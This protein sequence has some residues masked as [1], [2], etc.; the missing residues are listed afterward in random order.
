[1][2]LLPH[3][4]RQTSA[5]DTAYLSS[6]V[7][8]KRPWRCPVCHGKGIVPAGFYLSTETTWGTTGTTPEKC[9]G[10]MGTGVVIA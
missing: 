5:P 8:P 3:H 10:C 6:P 7:S 4:W 9:R 2:S 1:M